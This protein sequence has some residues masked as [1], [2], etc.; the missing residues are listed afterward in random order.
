[1]FE[2]WPAALPAGH[3]AEQFIRKSMFNYFAT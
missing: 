3:P 2:G 1:M